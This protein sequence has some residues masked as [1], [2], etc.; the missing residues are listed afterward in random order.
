MDRS[1]LAWFMVSVVLSSYRLVT[2]QL[3]PLR[4]IGVSGR[5]LRPALGAVMLGAAASRKFPALSPNRDHAN[6]SGAFREEC[7]HGRNPGT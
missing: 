1:A 2:W 5:N 3:L 4:G 7:R 6:S